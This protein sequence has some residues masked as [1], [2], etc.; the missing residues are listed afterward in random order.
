L[1]PWAAT[2]SSPVENDDHYYT[3]CRYVERNALR[4]CLVDRMEDWTWN[5]LWSYLHPD[6]FPT[7]RL[8]DWPLP[9]PAHWVDWV[10]Q[11]LTELEL[12]ALRTSARRGRPYGNPG[13]QE[14]V[15]KQ[16]GLEFTLRPPGRPRITMPTLPGAPA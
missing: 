12:N 3:V 8:A 7:V 16:L 14:S 15:A 2:K 1:A 6:N 13:W 4:A 5:G 9:R 10:N 11:P